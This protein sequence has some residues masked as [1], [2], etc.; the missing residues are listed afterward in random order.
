MLSLSLLQPERIDWLLEKYT[1]H[2]VS[3]RAAFLFGLTG[4]EALILSWQSFLQGAGERLPAIHGAADAMSRQALAGRGCER[5][6]GFRVHAGAGVAPGS[7]R[8]RSIAAAANRRDPFAPPRICFPIHVPYTQCATKARTLPV[9]YFG[10]LG[11][12]WLRLI[13]G[14]EPMLGRDEGATPAHGA[15]THHDMA[16][17][18]ATR[19]LPA[20][21]T[22][23]ADMEPAKGVEFPPTRLVES[24][25]R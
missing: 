13:V 24:T 19:G 12:P 11:S 5:V 14:P 4:D 9:S 22:Q 6:P 20:R 16:P 3:R 21:E 25:A 18:S 10:K 23:R 2:A 15:K 8:Q 7:G 1:K 17:A